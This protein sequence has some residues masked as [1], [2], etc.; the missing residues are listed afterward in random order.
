[1]PNTIY[2]PKAAK[3]A[4]VGRFR[5]GCITH[6]K[7]SLRNWLEKEYKLA[8]EFMGIRTG[9]RIHNMDEKGA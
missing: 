1:M 3:A 7:K 5:T 4:S 8:L 6:T 2:M 9:K